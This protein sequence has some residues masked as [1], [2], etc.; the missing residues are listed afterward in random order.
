[1]LTVLL[2]L[3]CSQLFYTQEFFKLHIRI[4]I[5]QGEPPDTQLQHQ[6]HAYAVVDI[7]NKKE[8]KQHSVS[9][10]GKISQW[11]VFT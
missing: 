11:V 8:H 7:S 2:E 3:F 10:N 1:M 4:S 6:M 5:I 9:I